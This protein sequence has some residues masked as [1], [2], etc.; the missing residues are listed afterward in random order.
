M[1]VGF[2]LGL[3]NHGEVTPSVTITSFFLLGEEHCL[4]NMQKQK[5]KAKGSRNSTN[6]CFSR[7][8]LDWLINMLSKVVGP[9][10]K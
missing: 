6:H 1:D 9:L 5:I 2:F 4:E 10:P 7:A 8:K 3:K